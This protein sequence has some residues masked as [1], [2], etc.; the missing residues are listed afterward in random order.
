M[1]ATM[2]DLVK[3]PC[4]AVGVVC[5]PPPPLEMANGTR[6]VYAPACNG[7]V[8]VEVQG[9]QPNLHLIEFLT[10]LEEF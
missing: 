5:G 10:L 8:W 3:L 2:F 7:L 6:L 4:G 1:V 9:K